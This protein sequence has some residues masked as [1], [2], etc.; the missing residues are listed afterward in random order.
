RGACVDQVLA[1]VED[2][3]QSAT[4]NRLDEDAERRRVRPLIDVQRTGNLLEQW[5]GIGERRELDPGNAVERGRR[6]NG[7][8][9]REA[10][11]TTA[12][13]TGE[14]DEPHRGNQSYQVVELTVTPDKAR[15]MHGQLGDTRAARSFNRVHFWQT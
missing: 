7:D 10:R 2:E 3:Q 12:A 14:R 6:T 1:V 13:G 9:A 4:A 8:L 5:L 15:E 11:L